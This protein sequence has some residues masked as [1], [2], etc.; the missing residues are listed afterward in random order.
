MSDHGDGSVQLARSRVCTPD[1]AW[2]LYSA[3]K[4]ALALMVLAVTAVVLRMEYTTSSARV[5]ELER[6]VVA[7]LLLMTPRTDAFIEF[8]SEILDGGQD[9]FPPADKTLAIDHIFFYDSGPYSYP[10]TI[11][12]AKLG[13]VGIAKLDG[14]ENPEVEVLRRVHE[15][16]DLSDARYMPF[17]LR[18]DDP[19]DL[20]ISTDYPY[21]S[22]FDQLPAGE[23]GVYLVEPRTRRLRGPVTRG[24]IDAEISD[25]LADLGVAA[26]DPFEGYRDA[27]VRFR[28]RTV[29]VPTFG[30][31]LP[32]PTALIAFAWA[33]LLAAAGL[34]LQCSPRREQSEPPVLP[35]DWMR[36]T[37]APLLN[38]VA[39]AALVVTIA[40]PVVTAGVAIAATRGWGLARI[41]EAMSLWWT[42]L[43]FVPGVLGLACTLAS[44][45]LLLVRHSKVPE[46]VDTVD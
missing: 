1:F 20:I 15:S 45:R 37:V 6:L 9:H 3:V 14:T 24:T 42:V 18:K 31:A 7:R 25:R 34:V 44:A 21:W 38:A 36:A 26:R 17:A 27:Q 28:N 10:V 32:V 8:E 46:P 30:L 11:P 12:H 35:E 4:P 16:H 39:G 2:R 33:S 5:E 13:K 23:Y 29:A 40:A 19:A 41:Q 22:G 43:A